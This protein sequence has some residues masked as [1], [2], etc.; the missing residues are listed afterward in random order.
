M[1]N[2]CALISSAYC[3]L[4]RRIWKVQGEFHQEVGSLIPT[5][6]S[7]FKTE[8]KALKLYAAYCCLVEFPVFKWLPGGY[9]KLISKHGK[10][11]GKS[12]VVWRA[13]WECPPSS[14]SIRLILHGTCDTTVFSFPS[15]P[16]C[17]RSSPVL[18]VAV[19]LMLI[20]CLYYLPSIS[21]LPP[22]LRYSHCSK[23][24]RCSSQ[25]L[26]MEMVMRM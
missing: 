10:K 16:W 26:G 21:F 18:T 12:N 3:Q 7:I 23:W 14:I 1:H 20:F 6:H 13:S 15:G 24:N 22:L 25:Q 9:K 19:A 11:E 17:P 4:L 2:S 5:G 8:S